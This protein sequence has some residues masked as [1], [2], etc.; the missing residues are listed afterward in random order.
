[1]VDNA[2]RPSSNLKAGRAPA[3]ESMAR[4][5]N[6]RVEALRGPLR[7]GVDIGGTFTDL[8]AVDAAGE[9]LADKILTTPEA[10]DDAVVDGIARLLESAG[11]TGEQVALVAHATTL[12][13]NALIERK[14]PKTALISTKGFSDAIEIGREHRFDM[15]DLR[16]ERPEPL[17]PRTLRYELSARMLAD[18]SERAPFNRGEAEAIADALR[19]DGVEAAAVCLLH[20][21]AN[22]A[23]ERALGEV[24]AAAAPDVMISLSSD[25]APVIRE[26]ERAST[27]LA[28]VYVRRIADRYLMRIAQRLADE[29]GVRAPLLVMHSAGGLSGA[30]LAAAQPIRFVQSG[31]AAGALAA[32][33]FAAD[34]GGGDDGAGD[35]LSFDMGGTTAKAAIISG[36]APLIA[37]D[38]EVDR[39]YRFLKGSGLPVKI[40]V[41]EMIEIGAGGGSIAQVDALG[42]LRIGPESAS[43]APGPACYGLGGALPT[44]TDANLLLGYLDAEFFLGGQ[45]RL[46]VEAAE[47]AIEEQVAQPLG[48][49]A[50][51][52]AWAIHRLANETMADA[53]RLHAVERGKDA[54]AACLC[55]FGGAGPAHAFGV[56]QAL[57]QTRIL[58][59]RAAGVMSA[60]GL[61]A[62]PM[63]YSAAATRPGPLESY[64]WPDAADLIAQLD[65]EATAALRAHVEPERLTLQREAEMRYR[66][67]G[68][69]IVVPVGTATPEA[70]ALEAA[71]NDAYRALY[72]RTAPGAGVDVIGWRVTAIGPFPP[73]APPPPTFGQ[74][75]T[76]QK[77][78]RAIWVPDGVRGALREAP[79][80]DRDMLPPG[81]ALSG[82]AI[83][84]ERDSTVV[85][86]ASAHITVRADGALLAHRA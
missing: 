45:M 72:G 31:P 56:A 63:S 80:Y 24:L 76:A 2:L 69:E 81:C 38:F 25:V 53:A 9:V 26:Y 30:D 79:V 51:E 23:H 4:M 77:G 22:P 21:Y 85:I 16:M 65:E 55:A 8:V 18:G 40:P 3:K 33:R 68:S 15:Y 27:T 78:A 70:A 19:A 44:V 48:L 82:P 32:A 71:F 43:A 14:G 64:D 28:N 57:R 6:N 60:L 52:A 58:Y 84:E 35:V 49:T 5:P 39:R 29:A 67:Q 17:A 75:S 50:L 37:P 7:I 83:I 59:P 42:R 1:M 86:P 36:G 41:I 47:A 61:L 66:K 46:S 11:A 54:R 12:F 34:G 10:P 73:I 74:V 62:A 20:A 13:T